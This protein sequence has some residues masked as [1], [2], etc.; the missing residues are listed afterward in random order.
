MR[1]RTTNPPLGG[2][3]VATAAAVRKVTPAFPG[4]DIVAAKADQTIG[5]GFAFESVC[6]RAP[7]Q[8]VGMPRA[9]DILEVP[10]TVGSPAHNLPVPR[11][12]TTPNGES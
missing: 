12:T 9:V 5:T 3:A 2:T 11:L 4:Q 1:L 7:E 8:S 6:G 10:Q